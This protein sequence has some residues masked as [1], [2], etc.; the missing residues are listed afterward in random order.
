[1]CC[2]SGQRCS[3][4]CQAEVPSLSRTIHDLLAATAACD[5]CSFPAP[6][7]A[8]AA[9]Y[10]CRPYCLQV[11]ASLGALTG[12]RLLHL[13]CTPQYENYDDT[14]LLAEELPKLTQLTGLI[15]NHTERTWERARLAAAMSDLPLQHLSMMGSDPSHGEPPLALPPPGRWQAQLRELA[16]PAATT[17]AALPQLA[18]CTRLESLTLLHLCSVPEEQQQAVL[19]FAGR[20]PSLVHLRLDVSGPHLSAAT[21]AP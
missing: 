20:P 9:P 16:L 15:I 7:R 19:A 21:S 6:S 13:A 1:M 4:G 11:P 10:S 8:Q 17:A 14:E 5:A 3:W 12:L 18:A 2:G